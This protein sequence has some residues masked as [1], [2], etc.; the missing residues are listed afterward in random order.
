MPGVSAC[1]CETC[2]RYGHAEPIRWPIVTAAD[3]WLDDMAG[4]DYQ[5]QPL[6]QDWARAAK[7]AEELGEVIA[8]LIGYIAQNPRKGH[9]HNRA[10]MLNEIA[11]VVITGI[12]SIQ[13][14]TKDIAQTRAVI[15]ASFAKLEGRLPDD[16]QPEPTE[17][18]CTSCHQTYRADQPGCPNPACQPQAGRMADPDY[19]PD[20]QCAACGLPGPRTPD[21]REAPAGRPAAAGWPGASGQ[22]SEAE[23]RS[24]PAARADQVPK[25]PGPRTAT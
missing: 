16:Y 25:R 20:I 14:F 22:P 6:A 18:Q 11:D 3:L 21:P 12:L 24:H 15:A 19:V 8:A 7:I 5:E 1:G 17:W 13:H 2:T 23:L 10:D 4:L 9:T